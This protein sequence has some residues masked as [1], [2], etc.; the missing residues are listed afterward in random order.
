[1]THVRDVK[2]MF[3]HQV[4]TYYVE[5]FDGPV[6]CVLYVVMSDRARDKRDEKTQQRESE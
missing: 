3:V 5:T 4:F 1:M 6:L 2:H